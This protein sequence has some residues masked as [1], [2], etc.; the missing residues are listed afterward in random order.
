M[1]S[2]METHSQLPVAEVNVDT[3]QHPIPTGLQ[4]NLDPLKS[5]WAWIVVVLSSLGYFVDVLGVSI[6]GVVRLKSLEDLGIPDTMSAG[7]SLINTQM[8]GMLIGSFF[9]GILG[10]LR[11]RGWVLFVAPCIYGFAHLAN[12]WITTLDEYR[13]LRL[14]GGFGLA[15]E[16]GASLSLLS[17]LIPPRKRG[18]SATLVATMGIL[19]GLAATLVGDMMPWRHTYLVGGFCAFF[20]VLLRVFTYPWMPTQVYVFRKKGLLAA[21]SRVFWAHFQSPVVLK[22]F[23][24]CFLLGMPIWYV[25][26]IVMPF[27]P[28]LSM[29]LGLKEKVSAGMAIFHC[30]LGVFVGDFVSGLASQW[31]RSRK[32]VLLFFLITVLTGF[33][34]LL[35]PWYSS[36]RFY[37]WICSLLGFGAGYWA[38]FVTMAA[39]QFGRGIRTTAAITIPNFV[40]A[41]VIP[42]SLM[43][44]FLASV[45]SLKISM[46]LCLFLCIVMAAIGLWNLRET[47]GV[48]L[49]FD[50]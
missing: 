14:L 30:S 26:G 37:Y 33:L 3:N 21:P 5:A 22:R 47:Y 12:G 40:R 39:E 31:L 17:E 10:D 20:L 42:F 28:E 49:N 4:T 46:L 13:M 23:L 25:L 50:D 8:L 34:L 27:A 19:G 24:W 41:S 38:V 44:G 48:D 7:I 11:G 9:W 18:Y 29:S 35:I 43:T 15:G 32:K 36:S 45:I 2:K 1:V 16:L 6:L